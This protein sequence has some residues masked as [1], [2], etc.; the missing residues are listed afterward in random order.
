MS[1][2][3]ITGAN[4]YVGSRVTSYFRKHG[5]E[6]LELVRVASKRDGQVFFDLSKPFPR[7]QLANV[8]ALVHCAYDFSTRDS[9]DRNNVNVAGSLRLLHLAREAGVPTIIFI[10]SMAAYDGCRSLYGRCKWIVEHEA[11]PLRAKIVRPGMVYGKNAGG[12]LSSIRNAVAKLPII[13]LLGHGHYPLFTVHEDDLCAMVFGV[14]SNT[15]P[16]DDD[17][18]ILAASPD[19]LDF[20]T[21]VTS[22][23]ASMGR[24]PLLAPVPWRLAYLT[25]RTFEILGVPTNL[26][27]DSI[28]S[29]VAR[30]PNA[31]VLQQCNGTSRFR[32]FSVDA[33]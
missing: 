11:K 9:P 5:W 6:T 24:K 22:L 18:P 33:I 25:L 14:A 19:M 8:D 20:R 7:H 15:L 1:V 28:V 13:P 32:P 26:R 4:G 21:L 30:N 31:A 3:A 12:L 29:L 16:D 23:A 27:S 10:S 2:C 17:Q